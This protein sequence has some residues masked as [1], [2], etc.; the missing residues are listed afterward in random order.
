MGSPTVAFLCSNFN[1]V[2]EEGWSWR[3]TQVPSLS[4]AVLSKAPF[5]QKLNLFFPD[6]FPFLGFS[7]DGSPGEMF[8]R[9]SCEEWSKVVI[10]SARSQQYLHFLTVLP[11]RGCQACVCV[12]GGGVGCSLG[13]SRAS[14]MAMSKKII[15][16][17]KWFNS[18]VHLIASSLACD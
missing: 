10:L 4:S 9:P 18:N 1:S 15:S 6:L 17:S 2:S 7:P 3:S 16:N 5:Q 13:A 14:I 8:T 11:G 12:D